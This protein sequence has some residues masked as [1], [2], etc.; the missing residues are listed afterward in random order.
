MRSMSYKQASKHTGTSKQ[1]NK[2]T[3]KHKQTSKQATNRQTCIQASAHVGTHPT[4][5]VQACG[6]L[7][8]HLHKI[9]P[10]VACANRTAH[11]ESRLARG[12]AN[13]FS[14]GAQP[15]VFAWALLPSHAYSDGTSSSSSSSTMISSSISDGNN[16]DVGNNSRGV[17]SVS[18]TRPRLSN[19]TIC[20]RHLLKL[21]DGL[22]V[23]LCVLCVRL[24]F[25]LDILSRHK[26]GSST[27]RRTGGT[28]VAV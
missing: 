5:A 26:V 3:H 12:A 13:A 24:I 15:I 18:R 28:F 16:D 27:R 6:Q 4:R 2:Q 8:T 21:D 11:G 7:G 23:C 25:S 17:G 20:G 1:A 9:A 10:R 14:I 19:F 22:C